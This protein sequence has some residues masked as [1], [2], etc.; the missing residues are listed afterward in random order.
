[1]HWEKNAIESKAFLSKSMYIMDSNQYVTSSG[2]R[3]YMHLPIFPPCHFVCHL[4]TSFCLLYGCLPLH[5]RLSVGWSY[6]W[7]P[8]GAER[9]PA[10]TSLLNLSAGRSPEPTHHLPTQFDI[11]RLFLAPYLS[12]PGTVFSG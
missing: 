7:A 9:S 12:V 4:L 10:F 6:R 2:I 1:M 11:L 8:C 5:E 3:R